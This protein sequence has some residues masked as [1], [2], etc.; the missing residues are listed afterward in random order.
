MV[1]FVGLAT[2]SYRTTA[3]QSLKIEFLK[4]DKM[5]TLDL[6]LSQ[7]CLVSKQNS[8]IFVNHLINSK[9]G[10]VTKN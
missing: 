2:F 6:V 10:T 4:K 9:A 7:N 3:G 1:A 8:L 5:A